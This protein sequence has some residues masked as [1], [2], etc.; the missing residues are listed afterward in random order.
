M[1]TKIVD[2]VSIT[3][4]GDKRLTVLQIL[5]VARLLDHENIHQYV[6]V[7][8][9]G[10]NDSLKEFIVDAVKRQIPPSLLAKLT[11]IPAEDIRGEKTSHG[12]RDQQIIK[13]LVA[14]HLQSDF[15]LLL[16]AKN[17][18]V[19]PALVTD[20]FVGDQP[21]T[22]MRP[23]LVEWLQPARASLSAFGVE[24]ETAVQETPPSVTPYMMITGEVVH[25]VERLESQYDTS[26]ADAFKHKLP[27]EATEFLLYWAHFTSQD[28]GL[29]P[30][31][32]KPAMSQT[33]YTVWPQDP[34]RV[35]K[36]IAEV[37][38]NTKV[39]VFGL[40]RKRLL[41]LSDDQRKRIE[42]LWRVN[43]LSPHESA[44]WFMEFIGPLN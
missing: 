11:F 28:N 30:Y 9:G 15:Y 22:F 12:W 31:T 1:G 26:L 39:P 23:T 40:H 7:L 32:H 5:S 4:G 29:F 34:A 44:D 19:H 21:R 27:P 37:H 38:G 13:L 2:L 20:F 42:D 6:I 24:D 3:W 17:H 25:M 33:L 10:N 41:Q 8:N 43:L 16:D 36:L 18:F 14:R 35:E